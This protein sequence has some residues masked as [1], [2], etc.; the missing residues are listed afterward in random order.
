[1]KKYTKNN[2]KGILSTRHE[3]TFTSAEN[4][5]EKWVVRMIEII[6]VVYFP[7]SDFEA[8]TRCTK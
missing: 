3:S 2:S 8:T 1:M 7:Y 4:D 5:E 6:L